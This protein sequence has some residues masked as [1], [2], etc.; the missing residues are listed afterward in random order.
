MRIFAVL[1]L[2]V[3][4]GCLTTDPIYLRHPQTGKTVQCGPYDSRA[5]HA[6]A[7]AIRE[8]Q[9]TEDFRAQGYVRLP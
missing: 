7:S 1:M 2:L 9:C 3:L 8:G 6:Q 4:T 5:L